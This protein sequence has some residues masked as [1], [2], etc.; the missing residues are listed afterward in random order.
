VRLAVCLTHA[1][2]MGWVDS[3]NSRRLATDLKG[4]MGFQGFVQSDWGA[5]H[6]TTVQQGLDMD[7]PMSATPD[8]SPD[9]LKKVPPAEI[10][11]AV[12]RTLASMYK[13]RMFDRE[14]ISCSPPHCQGWLRRNV[15][16]VEHRAIA[17][18]GA[19]ASIVLLQN[20]GSLL[21]LTTAAAAPYTIAVLG[22][23]AEA[24]V[25]DANLPG[26]GAGNGFFEPFIYKNEHFAKT[27]S[28]QT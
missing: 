23:A 6:G 7:M 12:T 25:F 15:T 2:L 24:K 10:D 9:E 5:G 26:N 20:T 11:D 19:A 16:G 21:P 13:L 1:W 28:G 8:Y 14:R 4:A 18:E 17:R 22:G 27:G 3:T